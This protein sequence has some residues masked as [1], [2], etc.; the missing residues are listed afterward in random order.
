[1]S[2]EHG[3]EVHYDGDLPSRSG[4]GSSSSFTVGLLNALK[5]FKDES[6][7]KNELAKQAIYIEQ[8]KLN[9]SVG[10]QDQIMAANGGF[11]LISLGKKNKWNTKNINVSNDY[12][13]ELEKHMLV[14]FTGISRLAND[15][16][17]KKID[18]I[19]NKKSDVKLF[20]IMDIANEAKNLFLHEGDLSKIGKLLNLS[21]EE[22]KQLTDTVTNDYIDEINE[23]ALNSGAFGGKLMGAGGGGF[24]FFLAPPKTHMKIKRNLSKV[25][26]WVPFK[27]D[28]HGSQIIFRNSENDN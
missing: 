8:K 15:H 26:V 7:A 16:A 23:I 28:N 1:M 10:V 22:K 4:I 20:R 5:S 17:R 18:N 13:K 25:K 21:W 11:Q 14:G 6:I 2:I 12:L 3:L 27:I 19:K 24:F 9:E